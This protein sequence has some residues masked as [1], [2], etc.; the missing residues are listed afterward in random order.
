MAVDGV[1]LLMLFGVQEPLWDTESVGVGDGDMLIGG[2][3]VVG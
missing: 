2:N 1:V 3:G